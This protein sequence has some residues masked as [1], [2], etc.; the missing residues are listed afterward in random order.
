M[1]RK[2]AEAKKIA[3]SKGIAGEIQISK[4]KNSR[5]VIIRPDG[6]KINFGFWDGGNHAYIDHGD[7]KK[8]KAW[9][10]RH[11]KILLKDGTPAYMSKD[12]PDYYAWRILW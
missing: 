2:L 7:I 4:A 5:F 11:S 10:A 12:S 9:R 6:K 1:D 3:K 8:R